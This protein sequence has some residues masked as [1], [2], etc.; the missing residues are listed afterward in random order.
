M[1]YIH[2]HSGTEESSCFYFPALALADLAAM[3]GGKFVARAARI[4]VTDVDDELHQ[5]AGATIVF[6]TSGSGIF[7][8]AEGEQKIRAGDVVYMPPMTSHLSVADKD[9]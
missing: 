1:D 8:S 4:E 6:I 9:T 5:H 3:H 7:R 2:H